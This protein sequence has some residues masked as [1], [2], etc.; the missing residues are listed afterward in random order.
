MGLIKAAMGAASGVMSDQWKDFIYC[1]SIPADVLV[2]KGHRRTGSRSSNRGDDNIISNGSGIAVNVGQCMIIV[3][4]GKVVELCAEPGTF[5][6]NN[7]SEPSVF[8][9]ELG[10]LADNAKSVLKEMVRRF[11]YG[12]D[13]GKDQRVYY[14]NTKE[15]MG[16]K[17]GT[18]AP[19]P[20]KVRDDE[21]QFSQTIQIRCFGEYSYRIVNPILFYTN[22]CGNVAEEYRRSEIES[23]L[24]SELQT[25]LQPAMAKISAMRIGYDE[26]PAHTMDI[27]D[28]LNQ[29]LS[30]K[31]GEKRGIQVVSFGVSS[32]NISEESQKA[33]DKLQEMQAA[34]VAGSSAA[35][36][37]GVLGNAQADAMRAAA[38]NPNGGVMGF[39]GMNMA[40]GAGGA[41]INNLMGMAQQQ[42]QAMPQ[43]PAA[44][45]GGW[46]CSCGHGGNQGKFCAECGKPKPEGWTCSC[47]TKNS[48]KFCQNCGKPKPEGP[49]TCVC[50][51]QNTG[52]FCQNCGKPKA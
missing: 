23:Q 46:T 22:V 3:E 39:M 7:S 11:T 38:A 28:A 37:A 19:I 14:F 52:K 21:L 4:S 29:V 36:M 47:G 12:G 20:F 26:L 25:A 9:G 5:T 6:Y 13:T 42:Q 49:W 31:W 33:L 35:M 34:R 43:Q 48:G 10:D 41:S 45:S 32:V 16:N 18:P 1:D 24:K 17:Y 50:G 15:I 27:A 51:T 30:Q 8:A 40:G 44:P 2:T